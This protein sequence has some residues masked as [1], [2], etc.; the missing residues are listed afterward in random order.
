[1]GTDAVLRLDGGR[2]LDFQS[3]TI[4]STGG[5]G[6]SGSLVWMT[7]APLNDRFLGVVM[8]AVAA[9]RRVFA[10]TNGTFE[11]GF[12]LRNSQV[13]L[14]APNEYIL[15]FSSGTANSAVIQGNTFVL[16]STGTTGIDLTGASSN[17]VVIQGN[18]FTMLNGTAIGITNCSAVTIRGNR[19]IG[20]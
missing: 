11:D 9:G 20:A 6:A 2:Y 3:H 16:S 13:T 17:G 10:S 4:V 14:P 8:N 18:T 5:G 19:I 15:T 1:L 12:E 7:G